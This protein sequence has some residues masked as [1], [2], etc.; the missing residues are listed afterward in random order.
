MHGK[1]RILYIDDY[2]LDRE[3][4]KDAL[5]QEHGG[6]EVTEASGRQEFEVLLNAHRFD[7]VLSDFNIA[8]FDGFQVLA[9]VHAHD[10]CLPVIIVTGTGSEEIAVMALK[11]GAADYVI[12]RPK[13]I[14]RLAQT[15][16]SA[17]E[18]QTLRNRQKK[19][20]ALLKESEAKYRSMMESITDSICICSPRLTI[21]YMNP[22][23][24]KRVGRDATGET[25]HS[26][27][28]GLDHR[29][30]WCVF[31][32]AAKGNS[33]ESTILSPLDGRTYRVTDMPIQHQNGS[34]S[35]MSIFRDITGYLTA[36]ADKEK[37][38]GQL[39]QAQRMETIGT[40]AGG[41]AHDFNNILYPI[42]G[43]AEMS[44]EDLPENHPIKENLK[45][46]L[47][48]AKRAR[49]LVKQILAFSNQ[50][51]TEQE[52]LLLKP[53]VQEAL[54]LLRSAIPSNIEIQQDLYDAP[55]HV[56]ANPTEIH[57]VVM[58]LCTNAY[59]AMEKSGGILRLCL[60]K[61]VPNPDLNLPSGDYC[62]ISVRD[63]G[64]GIPTEME[65]N[66]FDPYFT[67]KET[68]KGTGLGLSVVHGII[69]KYQGAITVESMPG[70]GS[71]FN[72]FLPITSATKKSDERLKDQSN[73]GGDEKILFV[74]DEVSITKLGVRLLERLGYRVTGKSSSIE[75]FALFKSAPDDF[76]LVITDMNMP[77]M[78]G[79]E[80]AAKLLEIR[81]DIPIILCTGFSERI[82]IEI[83]KSI[84]IR[85]YINK[86]ILNIDLSS[87]VREVLDQ[88][89]KNQIGEDTR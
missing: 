11:K 65:K 82:D 55:D 73:P 40:L 67:T 66:I 32:T 7:V 70:K 31:D 49:D 35:K 63:T 89:K 53:L 29:C 41:I 62:C 18:K 4:V 38:Q 83:A 48:G 56:L 81:P 13:H 69:K 34:V 45:D 15:I 46:I 39:L 54:K 72:V 57:E 75:A 14:Q 68:G 33:I 27:L 2:A 19:A 71:V 87:K 5:E 21:E 10:P 1:I 42:M 28:Y 78:V 51:P 9:A 3:L 17:I 25:C 23:M 30:D 64:I 60:T 6:F 58:N 77:G 80:L 50:R 26:A 47:Q 88:A 61:A 79:S 20:E 86:P 44:I 37:A 24:I 22:A 85:D 43:Y 76:D 74:D 12:K 16:F 36:L 8:G 84:G 59:H 52:I